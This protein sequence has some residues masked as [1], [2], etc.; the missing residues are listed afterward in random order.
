MS[1][2]GIPWWD[3]P[4]SV[5]GH[6]LSTALLALAILA[7]LVAAWHHYR[8]PYLQ[9]QAAGAHEHSMRWSVVPRG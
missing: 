9:R 7:L 1:S 5:H 2:Y 4:P 8:E 6:G 3:K